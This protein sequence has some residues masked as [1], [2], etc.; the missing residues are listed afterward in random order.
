MTAHDPTLDLDSRTRKFPTFLDGDEGRQVAL[1]VHEGEVDGGHAGA[2]RVVGEVAHPLHVGGVLA[3][4]VNP[5][6]TK[7]VEREMM[8][9]CVFF[10][11]PV[12]YIYFLFS[13]KST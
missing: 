1:L 2:R 6:L 3:V 11:E 13:C 12:F 8:K 9:I 4:A 7:G 5:H 10:V